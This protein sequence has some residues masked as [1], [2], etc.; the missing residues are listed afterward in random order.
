MIYLFLGLPN[1]FAKITAAKV[2]NDLNRIEK[3]GKQYY[4]LTIIT[5]KKIKNNRLLIENENLAISLSNLPGTIIQ[6]DGPVQNFIDRSDDPDPL[7]IRATENFTR[8]TIV[9]NSDQPNNGSFTDYM[10][11]SIVV[12]LEEKEVEGKLTGKYD[13]GYKHF[14]E[15]KT[16]ELNEDGTEKIEKVQVE[17]FRDDNGIGRSTLTDKNVKATIVAAPPKVVADE[18][19]QIYYIRKIEEN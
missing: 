17:F 8:E 16:G 6:I 14:I 12:L 11:K 2:T 19:I 10:A 7:S 18:T 13:R 3:D 9:P 5:Q 1:S 15:V 4:S